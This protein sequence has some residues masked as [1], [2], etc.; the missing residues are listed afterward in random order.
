MDT[1][2]GRTVL[3]TGANTGI[4]RVTAEVLAARGATLVL[5][6][7][8]EARTRP[9]LDAIAAAGGKASFLELDLGRLSS[10]RDAAERFLAT[11]A[12]L[13]VLV[14]NAGL[15]GARG[16]TADG[17]ELAFGTNHL[18]PYLFTRLLL[19]RL[20]ESGKA[21]IVNV[22]SRAHLSAKRIDWDALRRPTAHLTGLPEYAV[23]KLCNVLFTRSL[24]AGKAGE[25]ITSYALHPGAV[26]TDVWREVPFPFR[27]I[28]KRFM[29]TPEEGARTTIR[30]ASDPALEGQDGLYWVDEAPAR[31]NRAARDDG[32]RDEL[33]EKSAAWVGLPS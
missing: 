8:S 28:M 7:R 4:G 33:W 22:S 27:G 9:V 31:T 6:G 2:K 10:V 15:A 25:G 23:S 16:V 1:M 20:R 24:A 5:A 18:G 11:S 12:P 21:R 30:C 32:L 3:V 14:N 29:R 19:P 13:H 26:A 17:F